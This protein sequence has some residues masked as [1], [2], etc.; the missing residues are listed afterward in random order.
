MS[1]KNLETQIYTERLPKCLLCAIVTH[2]SLTWFCNRHILDRRC[3]FKIS[4]PFLCFY[5]CQKCTLQLR[6]TIV[7]EEFQSCCKK[8]VENKYVLEQFFKNITDGESKEDMDD[9]SESFTLWLIWNGICNHS[10]FESTWNRSSNHSTK[11]SSGQFHARA[12]CFFFKFAYRIWEEFYFPISTNL[13][14]LSEEGEQFNSVGDLSDQSSSW[15]SGLQTESQ[16]NFCLI[17]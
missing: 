17:S 3:S 7:N 13:R 11:K 2:T 5:L 14:K 9:C 8:I 10:C 1:G 6:R 16:R 4:Q 12:Q 15:G